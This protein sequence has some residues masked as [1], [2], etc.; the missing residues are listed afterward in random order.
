MDVYKV[1]RKKI[2]KFAETPTVPQDVVTP[3]KMKTPF[4]VS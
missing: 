3:D 1:Q 4:L 2:S